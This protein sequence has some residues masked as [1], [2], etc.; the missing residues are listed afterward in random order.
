MTKYCGFF[1]KILVQC[2]IF[3]SNWDRF[4]PHNLCSHYFFH[5]PDRIVWFPVFSLCA[6]SCSWQ[7]AFSYHQEDK[8]ACG[9]MMGQISLHPTFFWEKWFCLNFQHPQFFQLLF[10]ELLFPY[11]EGDICGWLIVD[12]VW[13]ILWSQFKPFMDSLVSKLVLLTET[14]LAMDNCSL[15]WSMSVFP[16]IDCLLLLSSTCILMR[17]SFATSK[18]SLGGGFTHNS[19]IPICQDFEVAC[20]IP[21]LSQ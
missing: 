5:A 8:S 17:V 1:A 20:I 18:E 2:R 14:A 9:P 11:S 3:P 6:H 15:F 10:C 13:P 7:F 12:Y 16:A 19:L 21:L 4:W